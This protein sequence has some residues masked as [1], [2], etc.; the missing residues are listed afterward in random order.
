M[1]VL[2]PL[3]LYLILFTKKNSIIAEI[4]IYDLLQKKTT[5]QSLQIDQSFFFH[6]SKSLLQ[7]IDNIINMFDSYRKANQVWIYTCS[8][9]FSLR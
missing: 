4:A 1:I 8:I 9:L 6:L 3:F 7:I 2:I 5:D